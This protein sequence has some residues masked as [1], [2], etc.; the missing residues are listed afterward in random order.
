MSER[1]TLHKGD[2][3]RAKGGPYYLTGNGQKIKMSERGPFRF[4]SYCEQGDQRWIEAYSIREGGFTV[5]SLSD[6][7]SILPG[8]YVAR[9]YHI[10]GRV[11][12]RNLIR[13]EG[14]KDKKIRGKRQV[15]IDADDIAAIKS[16]EDSQQSFAFDVGGMPD[17]ADRRQAKRAEAGR[18]AAGGRRAAV[19]AVLAGLLPIA[20]EGQ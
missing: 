5:L 11:T 14:R 6:R 1:V 18:R 16:A 7:D 10:C 3:F 15:V 19:Q 12:G 2:I 13:I 8:S 20:Q 4:V 17:K 9:P